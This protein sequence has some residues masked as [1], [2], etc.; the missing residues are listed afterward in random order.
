MTG[1]TMNPMPKA[2]PMKPMPRDR[3]SGVVTS[4]IYAE[5]TEMLAP[6]MPAKTRD[7][8]SMDSATAGESPGQAAMA[9][10]T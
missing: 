4:A 5:A 6:Q 7:T 2:M 10:R 8:S 9:N 3:F 1:P